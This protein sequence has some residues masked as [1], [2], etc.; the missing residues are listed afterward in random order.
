MSFGTVRLVAGLASVVGGLSRFLGLVMQKAYWTPMFLSWVENR[1]N[2]LILYGGGLPGRGG[3]LRIWL[4]DRC[5]ISSKTSFFGRTSARVTPLL[6]VGDNVDIGWRQGIYVGTRVVLGHNVRI[7]GEGSLIG[8]PGHPLDPEARARGEPESD[9][10]ARDIIL[11]DDVWLGRGVI[12]NAGVTIGAAT[13]VG[14][15]SVVTKSLPAGVLAAGNPARVIRI[16]DQAAHDAGATTV[17]AS[18]D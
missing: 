2:G 6:A 18:A 13:V 4:G 12:V 1:P 7:A 15:Q 11:G 10:Q 14:A 17:L 3:P 8:Y 16:I 5:R 9:D